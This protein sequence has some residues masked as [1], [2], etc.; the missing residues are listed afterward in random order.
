MIVRLPHPDRS[1]L[2]RI[3]EGSAISTQR[4]VVAGTEILYA[5]FRSEIETA[6]LA[7]CYN[8]AGCIFVPEDWFDRDKNIA[9]LTAFH[10]H[11]EISYKR[12][13]RSHAYAHRRAL[14]AELLAARELFGEPTA[15]RGYLR[16]RIEGYPLLKVPEP[17][18]VIKQ[19]EQILA[20]QRPRK[21]TLLDVVKQ[22]RL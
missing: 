22:Y 5:V 14:V 19:F 3:V 2:L 10:E 16:W 17:E 1:A 8:E 15:L 13:G 4:A 18:P 6:D 20:Q 12:S 7:A 21:G 9:D 11:L